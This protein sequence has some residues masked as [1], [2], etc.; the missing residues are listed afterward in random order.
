MLTPEQIER[1]LERILPTVE[2]PGRYTGGELNSV[3]KDWSR[4]QTRVCLAFPDIYDLGMSNL[5][6]AIL[7]DLPNPPHFS[8]P[9]RPPPRGR[10]PRPRPSPHHRRGPRRLQPRAG[11]RLH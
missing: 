8:P 9:P 4:V 3:V 11:G 7:Y 2:K 10:G 5:G 1:K 6:G